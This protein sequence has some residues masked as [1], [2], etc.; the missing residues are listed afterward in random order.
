MPEKIGPASQTYRGVVYPWKCDHIGH[1]NVMW[2]VGKFDE[3]TWNF[4]ATVGLGPSYLR[5]GT[6]A[7]AA[8]QQNISYKRELVAGDL[9][10]VDSQLLEIRPKVIR[11]SHELT[12]SETGEVAAS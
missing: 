8:V 9:V 1:M 5:E 6:H 2:Y 7:M 3:A 4:F 12:N 10:A 11:F